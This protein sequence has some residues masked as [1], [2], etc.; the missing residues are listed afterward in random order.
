MQASSSG[1]L[2]KPASTAVSWLGKRVRHQQQLKQHEKLCTGT[3]RHMPYA[4]HETTYTS[5]TTTNRGD[6]KFEIKNY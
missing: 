2:S 1:I 5:A 3:R 4:V 6:D